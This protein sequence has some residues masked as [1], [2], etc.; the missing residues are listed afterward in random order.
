MITCSFW[1]PV[2]R[3]NGQAGEAVALGH[4]ATWGVGNPRNRPIW[5]LSSVVGAVAATLAGLKKKC[6]VGVVGGRRRGGV[7]VLGVVVK[8]NI[9]SGG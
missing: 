7:V 5:P 6:D 8:W 4:S 2:S 3:Q 1:L 9:D